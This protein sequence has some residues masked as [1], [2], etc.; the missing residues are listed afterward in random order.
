MKERVLDAVVPVGGVRGTG[1]VQRRDQDEEHG[2]SSFSVYRAPGLRD[3]L[4]HLRSGHLAM[5]G[6][7]ERDSTGRGGRRR[8]EH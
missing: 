1:R 2:A 6:E 4:R 5:P 8:I 3:I 7:L